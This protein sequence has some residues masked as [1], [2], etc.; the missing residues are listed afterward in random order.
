MN[1]LQAAG[2]AE[3]PADDDDTRLR[4]RVGI[5]AGYLTIIA[6]LTLPLQTGV[7]PLNVGLAVGLS[8]FSL[9]NLIIFAGTH[10][11]ERYVIALI[12]AGAIF[13]PVAT[14]L[15]GRITGPSS[16]LVRGG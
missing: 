5:V 1:S 4:R 2:R 15:G 7:D 10:R 16:G 13:V 9:G 3:D 12:S 11:F 8:M 14:F 6:P